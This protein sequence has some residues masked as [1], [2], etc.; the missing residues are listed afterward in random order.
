MKDD[1][2]HNWNQK[3]QKLQQHYPQLSES[4]LTYSIGKEEEILNM[5]E[6]KMQKNRQEIRKWLS[7]MG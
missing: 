2:F 3:K 6:K 5:L 7:L 4:D 1:L